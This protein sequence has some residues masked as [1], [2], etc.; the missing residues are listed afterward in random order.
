MLYAEA[1]EELREIA[2]LLTSYQPAVVQGIK[3]AAV[4]GLSMGLEQAYLLESL[5][6]ERVANIVRTSE[7]ANE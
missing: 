5:Y 3:E 2:E 4:R 7:Q 6:G 1:S